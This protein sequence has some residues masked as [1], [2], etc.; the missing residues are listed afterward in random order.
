LILSTF[1]KAAVFTLFYLAF[2]VVEGTLRGLLHRQTFFGALY[3]A[4]VT[5]RGELLT[6][7][8]VMFFAFIP[9]F[10]LMETRRVLGADK[11]LDL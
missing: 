9:F 11:F 3:A 2:H 8:L 10:A 5:Q 7:A 6:L 4:T 1:H